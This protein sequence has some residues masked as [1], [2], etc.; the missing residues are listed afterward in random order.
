PTWGDED[1]RNT[2]L[3]RSIE[4]KIIWNGR[5]GGTTWFHPRAC[6]IHSA[7]KSV[8]LMTL[9]SIGGSDY[10]GPVYW[11]VTED[12]G[13]TWSEPEPIFSLGR[14]VL[15]GDLQEGV[16]DVVPEYHPKTKVVLAIGH[17]VYYREGRLARPQ[18]KRY[19]VYVVRSPEGSWSETRKLE[20]DDP[21][22]TRIYS[23]GCGQRVTM[24][25]GDLLI[26]LSFG[27]KEREDRSV[28]TVLCSFDGRTVKIKRCGNKLHNGVKRGLLEPSLARFGG[29]YYMTIRAEDGR[30]YVTSSD[31]GLHWVEQRAWCWDDGEPL[32]MSTTQQHWLVHSEGLY[33]VYTR[34]AKGNVKVF[35]W[36]AP[37]Y[38]AAVD[39]ES[40]RLIRSTERVVFPLIG[41]GINEAKHVARMGNFHTTS[42]APEESWV[43]VGE[44]LPADGWRGDLLMA[45]IRW[46]K[47]N[48]L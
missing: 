33:L 47:P 44:C 32:T 43:T 20:W 7:S 29:R 34:K 1:W 45:R 42:A 46:S 5:V 13:K 26:P 19:P 27:P 40:L 2:G 17:N 30:G 35:R 25:N 8:G 48:R 36:R 15:G 22:A 39:H 38:M 12:L 3:V 16:C 10:F 6:M 14:R 18:L 4:N 23:C 41:D 9:Q 21:R 31:D 37:L 24:E 28:S 11:S